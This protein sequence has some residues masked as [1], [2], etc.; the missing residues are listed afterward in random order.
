MYKIKLCCCNVKNNTIPDITYKYINKKN[1]SINKKN[2][3]DLKNTT[4]NKKN[5][6]DLKNTTINK[7]N[8]NDLTINHQYYKFKE[9]KN[10]DEIEMDSFNIIEN[11]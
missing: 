6:N 10:I 7:K 5:I 1:T 2:I 3:N 8:I 4:I 9:N 11:Y